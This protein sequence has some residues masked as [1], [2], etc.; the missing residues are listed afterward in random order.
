M[1]GYLHVICHIGGSE[2]FTISVGIILWQIWCEIVTFYNCSVLVAQE[3]NRLLEE[4]Q[5]HNF[6]L[7]PLWTEAQC[8]QIT[9]TGEKGNFYLALYSKSHILSRYKFLYYQQTIIYICY[10]SETRKPFLISDHTLIKWVK[11]QFPKLCISTSIKNKADDKIAEGPSWFTCL[12]WKDVMFIIAFLSYNMVKHLY[13]L[14]WWSATFMKFTWNYSRSADAKWGML[15]MVIAI[16]VAF[17]RFFFL[18]LKNL[19]T[20]HEY[21]ICFSAKLF[22]QSIPVLTG[23]ALTFKK[24]WGGHRHIYAAVHPNSQVS[25]TSMTFVSLC[26]IQKNWTVNSDSPS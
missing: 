13:I 22:T 15:R 5:Q 16:V 1:W 4:Q 21:L 18:M 17:S 6:L 26:Y 24:C 20:D 7:S 14:D 19:L 9:F 2:R 10:G 23:K 8:G 12:H 3:K 11:E 25:F